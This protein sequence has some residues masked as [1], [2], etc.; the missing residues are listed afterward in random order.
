[1]QRIRT[2][3]VQK[4]N[5]IVA[6]GSFPCVTVIRRKK[7][8]MIDVKVGRHKANYLVLSSETN[9]YEKMV[10]IIC[11]C[12]SKENYVA[13]RNTNVTVAFYHRRYFSRLSFN[14]SAGHE[15]NRKLR[16]WSRICVCVKYREGN[17]SVEEIQQDRKM[18]TWPLKFTRFK[19]WDNTIIK[20]MW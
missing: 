6:R 14:I 18:V 13:I 15:L 17:R 12:I 1:M 3:G 5:L 8:A 16:I 20:E 10:V 7:Y 2:R 9:A 4:L 11:T 19:S